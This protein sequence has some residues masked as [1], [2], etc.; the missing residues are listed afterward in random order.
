MA[1]YAFSDLHGEYKLF[2]QI[3]EYIQKDDVVYCLGDCCDRGPDGIKIIQEVLKDKRFIY[4]LGNHEA[5]LIDNVATLPENLTNA[6]IHILKET[7]GL[8]SYNDFYDLKEKER[9]E[10]LKELKNL[11]LKTLYINKDNKKIFLSHCGCNPNKIFDIDDKTFLWDRKHL[12]TSKW[13]WDR[14]L[15]IVHG[16]TPTTLM[17]NKNDRVY[18]YCNKHKIDIDTGATFGGTAALLN[19]DTFDIIYFVD[20]E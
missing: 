19:L 2:K 17:P 8:K 15:Y 12:T 7:E 20:K 6:D 4:L 9:E 13:V 14:D 1:T 18:F 3:Q 11:P 16:H 10:L 5:M